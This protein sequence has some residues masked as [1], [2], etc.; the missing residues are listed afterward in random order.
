MYRKTSELKKPGM[1]KV[2]NLSERIYKRMDACT[3]ENVDGEP[4]NNLSN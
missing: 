4:E 2:F 3:T 1:M